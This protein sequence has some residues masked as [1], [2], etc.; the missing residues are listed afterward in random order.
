MKTIAIFSV[1]FF[2]SI[3]IHANTYFTDIR[4]SKGYHETYRTGS[5]ETSFGEGAIN[6]YYDKIGQPYY[7]YET[8]DYFIQIGSLLVYRDMFTSIQWA[9]NLDINQTVLVEWQTFDVEDAFL[10][11]FVAESSPQLTKINLPGTGY[12]YFLF[13]LILQQGSAFEFGISGLAN[14]LQSQIEY[15]FSFYD[16]QD[17]SGQLFAPQIVP[18][19]AA[20]WLFLPSLIGFIA[21]RRRTQ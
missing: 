15:K 9:A 1:L 14:S 6:P 5:G 21:Y 10:G 3:G 11:I 4:G 17:P 8:D 20:F 13:D 16:G 7:E 12:G 18:V 2:Y 19:P